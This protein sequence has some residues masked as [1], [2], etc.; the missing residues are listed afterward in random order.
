MSPGAVQVRVCPEHAQQLNFRKNREALKAQVKA[1]KKQKHKRGSDDA[2]GS[3]RSVEDSER[4]PA[5]ALTGGRKRRREGDVVAELA[6]EVGDTD[7]QGGKDMLGQQGEKRGNAVE[8]GA[9]AVNVWKGTQPQLEA[10][11]DE[12]FDEYFS[13]MFL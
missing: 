13:G 5:E 4:V 11:R 6:D 9:D 12:E 7:T 2:E 3:R 10:S 1:A 8:S